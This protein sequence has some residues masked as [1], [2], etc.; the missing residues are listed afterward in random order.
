M[1]P[2]IY[3]ILS[4]D[5]AVAALVA[6]RIYPHGEAPADVEKPYVTWFLVTGV[7]QNEL[8]ASPATDLCAVQLDCWHLAS[9]GIVALARAVRAAVEPHAHV[10]AVL[11]NG[12][13]PETGI[14]RIAIQADYWLSR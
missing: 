13:E 14:Y 10:T 2:P 5:T 8:D 11:L 9:A 6:D 3:D 4:A 1:L 12:K 7:P